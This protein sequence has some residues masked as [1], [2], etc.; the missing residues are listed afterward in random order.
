MVTDQERA[1]LVRRPTHDVRLSEPS[2]QAFRH[3]D[4]VRITMLVSQRVI[5]RLHSGRCRDTEGAALV[6][7]L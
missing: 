5:D 3:G 4:D 6:A 7:M 2:W 1:E